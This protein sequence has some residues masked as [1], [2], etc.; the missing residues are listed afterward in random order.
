M[1]HVYS[2]I[3]KI[4]VNSKD[5]FSRYHFASKLNLNHN[6]ISTN[7]FQ[8]KFTEYIYIYKIS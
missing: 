8:E 4:R 5:M 3:Y 2:Y 6:N 1:L 7:I